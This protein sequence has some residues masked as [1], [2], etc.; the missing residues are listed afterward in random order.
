MNRQNRT[1]MKSPGTGRSMPSPANGNFASNIQRSP[2]RRALI[3]R[4]FR[5]HTDRPFFASQHEPSALMARWSMS[6]PFPD[7]T[8]KK[9][10]VLSSLW[11][12][13]SSWSYCALI[14][15]MGCRN[16]TPM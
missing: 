13:W 6:S 8:R 7:G 1:P 11:I 9:I 12:G 14:L 4:P 2:A 15:S 16:V 3:S 5:F 10:S